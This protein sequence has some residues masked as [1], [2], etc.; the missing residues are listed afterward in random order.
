MQPRHS[1]PQITCGGGLLDGYSVF[2]FMHGHYDCV[3]GAI[4]IK[5]YSY[6]ERGNRKW[7][8]DNN[9]HNRL[10]GVTP[11][12][13]AIKRAEPAKSPHPHNE[14]EPQ[15][16][17]AGT[18]HGEPASPGFS[19]NDLPIDNFPI[20]NL[21]S[22]N[23]RFTG[24]EDMLSKIS[25]GLESESTVIVM[26]QG[27]FGKTQTAIE[28]AYK[29][30]SSYECVWYFNAESKLRLED[31]FRKFALRVVGMKT[32]ITEDFRIV[33]SVI[34]SWLAEHS[35]CLFIFDNA[36]GCPELRD[37]L[38]RGHSRGHVLVNTRERLQ[39]VIGERLEAE[40]FSPADAVAFFENRAAGI[41]KDEAMKLSNTLGFLPLA[42]EQA[43]SYIRENKYTAGQ[44]LELLSKYGLRVLNTPSLDTDYDKTILT[45]WKITFDKIEQEEQ[46]KAAVQLFKL[47]AYCAPDDIPLQM[48]IDGRDKFP[49]PLSDALNP[50]DALGHDELIGRLA[51]YSLATLSGRD[52][53]GGALLS[54]HRLIQ[55]V[56]DHNLGDEKSWLRCCLDVA[57]EIFY[58][59]YGSREDFDAFAL[60]MPH[61]LKIARHAEQSLTDDNEALKSVAYIYSE[62]G[63]GLQKS[64]MYAEALEWHRK[65]LAIREKELGT[66]HPDTAGTYNNIAVV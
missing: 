36:E 39:G 29:N 22:R 50:D 43:A 38:P 30:A 53:N 20:N 5:P 62:A 48:F 56:I 65:D 60:A 41:D 52:K 66:E 11:I 54:V 13:L 35:S 28:Y 51:R 25:L 6:A 27:G 15:P 55:A 18:E 63:N 57:S 17:P 8:L 45:T 59:G 37:Y 32:A 14:L 34:D 26:G 16:P 21:P 23:P 2:S 61:A 49:Q 31:D 64:G 24:R 44:Y 10:D 46:S 33:R 9:L 40:V 42:L 19:V 12:K 7:H 3:D 58:Y 4:T 1:I 47:C